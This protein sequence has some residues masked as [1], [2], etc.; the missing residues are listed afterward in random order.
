[1][2]KK[3]LPWIDLVTINLF[4]LGLNF[5]N[6]AVGTIFMPYL[7]DSFTN[8]AVRNTALGSMRTAG[9]VIAMLVQPAMGLLSDRSMSRFG[10]RRPFLLV[11][12]LLD[13]VFLTWIALAGSFWSLLVAVLLIQFSS[14]VSHGPLQA[15]IPDLVPE[16][17]RGRASAI[18]AV[19]ELLP[20]VLLGLTIAPLVGAGYFGWA[21]A[22]TGGG[23][24]LVLVITW[25]TVKETPLMTSVS[26]PLGPAMSRVLGMLAG[27]FLGLL[28]GLAAG[29]V[30]GGL[31]GL[32]ALLLGA[33]EHAWILGLAVGGVAAMAAAVVGGVWSGVRATLGSL[34]P[35]RK[36]FL[37]W[38]VNRLMFLAA[39]TSIQG[40]APFF[41]MYAFSVSSERAAA[42]TGQLM[43]VVG[44]F[45]L[46]SAIPAGWLS[47]RY[48]Q[49]SL[50]SLSGLLAAGGTAIILVTVWLPDMGMIYLAGSILGLATGLFVTINWALGTKLVPPDE[51]GRYLGV[52]NLAG[53]GAGMI[54]S[55]IGGPLA[56]LLNRSLPG[57]GYF[58]I[59][60]AYLVLFLLSIVSLRLVTSPGPEAGSDPENVA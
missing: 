9:L 18:K 55:G 56:D 42:L 46:L 22:V 19:F 6:N 48:N 58:V 35:N 43:T 16:A 47:D 10:R 45:T 15:L 51:A 44:L 32:S 36:G 29:A 50:L 2:D 7:V 30:L 23:L 4:W 49:K 39:I 34:P 59:F 31:A 5:R 14:N 60:F 52:S 21:V 57:L 24:V 11:G 53:A 41:L 25:L 54:G 33:R 12:V 27:I 37:W 3:S 13:L 26:A 17:Q 40:F 28:A 38:V 20:V 8:E 1:M